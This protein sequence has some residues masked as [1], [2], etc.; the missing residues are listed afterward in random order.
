MRWWVGAFCVCKC[1][2]CLVGGWNYCSW[3]WVAC[4]CYLLMDVMVEEVRNEIL[5]VG[6]RPAVVWLWVSCVWSCWCR[7]QLGGPEL[8]CQLGLHP[9]GLLLHHHH[10]YYWLWQYLSC[11]LSWPCLLYCLCYHWYPL[12][13]LCDGWYW[14]DT[15]HHHQQHLSTIQ[16]E[17]QALPRQ[18]K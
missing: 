10:H 17:H 6:A 3:W 1:C 16:V 4:Q 9:V 18:T 7:G 5:F 13:P 14:P 15:R 11:H 12:H 2:W 8:H